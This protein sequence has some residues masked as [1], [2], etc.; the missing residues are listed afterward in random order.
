MHACWYLSVRCP[1]IRKRRPS[2]KGGP[3]RCGFF[4]EPHGESCHLPPRFDSF[5]T[6]I[7][8]NVQVRALTNASPLL[9]SY[10]RQHVNEIS[11]FK[12]IWS[13]SILKRFHGIRSWESSRRQRARARVTFCRRSEIGLRPRTRCPIQSPPR[14]NFHSPEPPSIWDLTQS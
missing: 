3:W 1:W 12:I 13:S 7:R 9:G 8:T 4:A 10:C 2:F 11:L 14:A 6:K 5:P